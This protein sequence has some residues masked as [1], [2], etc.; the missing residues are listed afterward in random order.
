[1]KFWE[2][3]VESYSSSCYFSISDYAASSTFAGYGIF[4][5]LSFRSASLTDLIILPPISLAMS[6]FASSSTSSYVFSD[7]LIS[8][9]FAIFCKPMDFC[10]ASSVS[11]SYVARFY[12]GFTLPLTLRDVG[13]EGI[14]STL[15]AYFK[16]YSLL[17]NKS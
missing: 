8:I 2:R 13:A 1:M 3:W 4:A 10:A 14:A 11:G 7:N 16:S 6:Y 17:A 9:Y 12:I 5:S 15:L